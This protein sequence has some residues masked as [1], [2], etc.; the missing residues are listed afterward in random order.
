MTMIINYLIYSI[1]YSIIN[2]PK[3]EIIV[4]MYNFFN[5]SNCCS[6]WFYKNILKHKNTALSIYEVS[7]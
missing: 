4:F 1:L 7:F 2:L 3:I 5:R 6:I